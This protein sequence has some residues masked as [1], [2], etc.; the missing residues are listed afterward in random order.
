LAG[1]RKR[2]RRVQAPSRQLPW[3]RA[4]AYESWLTAGRFTLTGVP[5]GPSRR[6]VCAFFNDRVEGRVRVLLPFIREGLLAIPRLHATCL[7]PIAR[8]GWASIAL[9][10]TRGLVRIMVCVKPFVM[11]DGSFS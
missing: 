9:V 11:L 2:A 1:A 7:Q 8:T 10:L 4:P 5:L 6:H 3:V